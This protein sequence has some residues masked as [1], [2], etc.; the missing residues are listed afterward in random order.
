MR[1]FPKYVS[2]SNVIGNHNLA[3]ICTIFFFFENHPKNL[4][5]SYK[6]DVGM[7][8]FEGKIM[9]YNQIIDI[10]VYNC[11]YYPKSSFGHKI[12]GLLWEKLGIPDRLTN[13]KGF[14]L[15]YTPS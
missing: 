3:I 15:S 8:G 2:Q 13:T 11:H 14:S 7:D 5:P 1:K 10:P 12:Q 6:V 4:D 9:S